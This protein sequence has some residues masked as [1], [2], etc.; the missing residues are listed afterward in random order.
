VVIAFERVVGTVE[1]IGWQSIRDAF[2]NAAELET[3]AGKSRTQW[4][5]AVSDD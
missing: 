4:L 5:Y 2:K 3:T 1:E